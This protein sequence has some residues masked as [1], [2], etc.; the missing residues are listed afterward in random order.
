[1]RSARSGIS[2]CVLYALLVL[3]ER[4][5]QVGKKGGGRGGEY[6]NVI[7]RLKIERCTCLLMEYLIYS[8]SKEP[9]KHLNVLIPFHESTP[10]FCPAIKPVFKTYLELDPNGRSFLSGSLPISEGKRFKWCP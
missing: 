1:M 4:D 9:F 7:C 5:G 3:E 10:A 2:R 6:D 8:F